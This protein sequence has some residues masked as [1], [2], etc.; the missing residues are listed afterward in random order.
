MI[1]R[2][3]AA[4]LLAGCAACGMA[5]PE[6]TQGA[7]P[8]VD[9]SF[10]RGPCVARTAQADGSYTYDFSYQV[11]NAAAAG[12]FTA[13]AVFSSSRASATEYMGPYN[14]AGHT[15]GEIAD[16]YTSDEAYRTITLTLP[17][18]SSRAIY[19]AA[20]GSDSYCAFGA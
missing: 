1:R 19:L 16:T 14:V 13:V 15:V 10:T 5:P 18:G 7:G 8:P 2:A 6:A 9:V 3:A 17:G 12:V 11:T 20:E 4:L